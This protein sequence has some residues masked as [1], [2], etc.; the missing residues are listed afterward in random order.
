MAFL[1]LVVSL[2]LACAIS[3]YELP[4]ANI[5]RIS[6]SR[7]V[8]ASRAPSAAEPALVADHREDSLHDPVRYAQQRT[9]SPVLE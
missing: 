9:S 1:T 6:L 8:I 5:L 4:A 7:S 2:P 3:E